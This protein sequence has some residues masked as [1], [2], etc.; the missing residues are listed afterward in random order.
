VT[1][2]PRDRRS[3]R[4]HRRQSR[5]DIRVVVVRPMVPDPVTVTVRPEGR[6]VF[7]RGKPTLDMEVGGQETDMAVVADIVTEVRKDIQSPAAKLKDW[8]RRFAA[9]EAQRRAGGRMAG[10]Y[11]QVHQTRGH[12]G[13]GHVEDTRGAGRAARST[14]RR[15]WGPFSTAAGPSNHRASTANS[16]SW[17]MST[18]TRSPFPSAPGRVRASR[19]K[20]CVGRTVEVEHQGIQNR[21][22][23]T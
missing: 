12:R 2:R 15:R 1:G 11:R 4:Q 20:K 9:A 21:I 22:S 13:P 16:R 6:G 8:C 7:G 23:Q 5:A 18:G 14:C 17:S 19:S 3:H 10:R